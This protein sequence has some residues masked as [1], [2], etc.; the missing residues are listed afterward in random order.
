MFKK[1]LTSLTRRTSLRSPLY[2]VTCWRARY[3]T[4]RQTSRKCSRLGV[5]FV[6]MARG[7]AFAL[8]S[9]SSHRRSLV[10]WEAAYATISPSLWSDYYRQIVGGGGTQDSHDLLRGHPCWC[11][12]RLQ[13]AGFSGTKWVRDAFLICGLPGIIVALSG[14]LHQG[15][16]RAAFRVD[17]QPA[18]LGRRRSR[19]WRE[20]TSVHGGATQQLRLPRAA[21]LT[22]LHVSSRD[23][24]MSREEGAAWSAPVTSSVDSAAPCRRFH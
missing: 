1:I 14:A 21:S 15:A 24:G 11:G 17:K 16:H 3:R 22:G 20:Q 5:G 7:G 19:C 4:L 9:R 8:T 23:R 10:E 18:P 2:V 13:V 12:H 6:P